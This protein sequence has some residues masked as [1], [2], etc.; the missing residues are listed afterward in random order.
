M[1]AVINER[2]TSSATSLGNGV[3]PDLV[4]K[5]E[6]QIARVTKIILLTK[7]DGVLTI[8]EDRTVR[9]ILKRD[10]GQFWPSIVEYL[11]NVP[12]A[13]SYDEESMRLFVGL[14]NGCVYEYKVAEDANS[15][16]QERHWM[17]HNNAVTAVVYCA[18]ANVVFSCSKDKT[19]VWYC[20]DTACKIGSYVIDSPCTAMQYDA[21]SKFIFA[22]A[23]SGSIFILR[24]VGNSGQLVSKLSAHTGAITDLAWDVRRQFLF[25]AST[26]FLVIMWDIGGKRGQ[27]YELNGHDSKLTSLALATEAGRL[28]S[29]DESGRLM[30]WDLKAKRIM[31][32][33]WRDSDRC[34]LCDVPFFWNLKVMWDRKTVGVRRHHCRTCGSSVCSNCCNNFTKFP[35]MG[36]EKPAR[37]CNTCH[38]KMQKYPEQ[39]DLTPLAVANDMRQG[40]SVMDLKD[41]QGK[42]VTV[43]YDRV[44]LLW[45]VTALL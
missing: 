23:Y 45:D 21:D 31:A 24:I 28:F 29:A 16:T 27:C 7:E 6:A 5:L 22:G 34:E 17:A 9:F 39:F 12:T 43:G 42:L 25:S 40:V 41:A 36:F 8:G 20:A 13:L 2:A 35:A 3:K 15:M 32:P 44:I 11:P 37:I 26:D 30:C 33:A 38:E 10:S 1:S 4:Q 19:I 14:V 18:A